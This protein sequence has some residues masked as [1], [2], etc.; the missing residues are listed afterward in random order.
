MANTSFSKHTDDHSKA[1]QQ[2]PASA[3]RAV[4][5]IS[6]YKPDS[7]T[8]ELTPSIRIT[9]LYTVKLQNEHLVRAVQVDIVLAL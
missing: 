7:L 5:L 6:N 3:G 2:I 8:H 1:I 4:L 9:Y